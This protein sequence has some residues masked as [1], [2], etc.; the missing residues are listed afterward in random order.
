MADEII[1]KISRNTE[2]RSTTDT[3]SKCVEVKTPPAF[4]GSEA[5]RM[6]DA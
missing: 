4:A 5:S 6:S 3:L 2:S 1:V